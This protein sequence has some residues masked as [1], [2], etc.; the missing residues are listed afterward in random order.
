MKTSKYE[1]MHTLVHDIKEVQNVPKNVESILRRLAQPPP[2]F[3]DHDPLSKECEERLHRVSK[4]IEGISAS[5]SELVRIKDDLGPRSTTALWHTLFRAIGRA[6]DEESVAISDPSL[7]GEVD[8][9]LP[10][11]SLPMEC[12]ASMLVSYV[13]KDH[14]AAL[15]PGPNHSSRISDTSSTYSDELEDEDDTSTES[16]ADPFNWLTIA[17]SRPWGLEP[18]ANVSTSTPS[19][20]SQPPCSLPR[21]CHIL[22][23]IGPWPNL[24]LPVFCVTDPES[25]IPVLSS[26]AYQRRIWNIDVP[27]IGIEVSKY[28]YVARVHVAWLDPPAHDGSD[29]MHVVRAQGGNDPAVGVFDMTNANTGFL[30]GIFLMSLR[31]QFLALRTLIPSTQPLHM[32]WRYDSF[33]PESHSIKGWVEN[34]TYNSQSAS[35]LQAVVHYE[36]E[37]E[38]S[39]K[40]GSKA[41]STHSSSK[42]AKE[43][44]AGVDEGAS[45]TSWMCHRSAI[46]VP[47][48]MLPKSSHVPE[49]DREFVN[50]MVNEYNN[51]TDF[52]WPTQWAAEADI[53]PVNDC[54]AELRAQLYQMHHDVRGEEWAQ[55]PLEDTLV[56][57]L[58]AHFWAVFD[59]TAGAFTKQME[60]ALNEAESRH[61]WDGLLYQFFT[62]ADEAMSPYVLLER[63]IIFPPNPLRRALETPQLSLVIGA[64]TDMLYDWEDQCIAVSRMTR[65]R[66]SPLNALHDQAQ[67]ATTVS[68]QISQSFTAMTESAEFATIVKRQAEAEPQRGRCDAVLCLPAQSSPIPKHNQTARF[69]LVVCSKRAN[70]TQK[71]SQEKVK[72]GIQFLQPA[73][74]TLDANPLSAPSLSNTSLLLPSLIAEYKKPS[75]ATVLYALNQT[76]M[77]CVSAVHF[78]AQIGIRATPV[79]GLATSGKQ[80]VVLIASMSEDGVV[81]V[82]ERNLRT[83]DLSNVLQVYHFSTFLLRLRAKSKE[84]QNKFG[85]VQMEFERRLEAGELDD[86]ALPSRNLSLS[87]LQRHRFLLSLRKR[88]TWTM[89]PRNS[90]TLQFMI[91]GLRGA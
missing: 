29:I 76:R 70:Q 48:L 86:W 1:E 13:V 11:G 35:A 52:R 85:K 30:L 37:E 47:V 72:G 22:A 44:T 5:F 40:K 59:A 90:E 8:V 25:I 74:S 87:R 57:I 14:I 91:S 83:F 60:L 6:C 54:H 33:G 41:S 42:F 9:A 50:A 20:S 19:A 26:V 27:V 58:S 66:Q 49:K 32:K 62:A 2:A 68:I 69:R 16:E 3:E 28:G 81:Y 63:D 7:S 89:S 53:P 31:H 61:E 17:R 65:N 34:T 4:T 36:A 73:N 56:P 75:Q 79:Y 82:F 39:R 88:L 80:G 43:A 45:I 78:L 24:V 71:V 15:L 18:F 77:Y 67:A 84:L 51:M 64:M 21:D 46:S 38:S 12:T 23:G 55:R 10:V